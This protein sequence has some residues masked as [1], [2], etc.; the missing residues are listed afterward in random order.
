MKKYLIILLLP[1]LVFT[2]SCEDESASEEIVSLSIIGQWEITHK[3]FLSDWTTASEQYM[4]FK[5]AVSMHFT[6]IEDTSMGNHN[7]HWYRYFEEE[8]KLYT[9]TKEPLALTVFNDSTFFEYDFISDT[10]TYFEGVMWYDI[11]IIDSEKFE[12]NGSISGY[13][14]EKI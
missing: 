3:Y 13:R 6:L 1:L 5:D 12:M 4:T 9:L 7:G 2:I 8:N 11:N 10:N 14:L